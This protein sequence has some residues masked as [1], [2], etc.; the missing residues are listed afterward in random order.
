MSI[1]G[2]VDRARGSVRRLW[3]VELYRTGYLLLIGQFLA[4]LSGGVFWLLAA[5][6]YAPAVVGTG[7]AA[8]AAMQLLSGVA[9]LNMSSALVRFVPVA[10]PR[11]RAMIGSALAV[12]AALS[13]LAAVIFIAGLPWWAPGLAGMLGSP[14]M[15]IWFVASTIAW[16]VLA[17]IAPALVSVSRPAAV[18]TINGVFGVGRISFVIAL[19]ALFPTVG[20]W[21]SWTAA[22]VIAAVLTLGYLFLRVVPQFTKSSTVTQFVPTRRDIARYVGPD[23]AG[24]TCWFVTVM[25]TPLLVFNAVGPQQAAVFSLAWTVTVTLYEIATSFGQSQLAAGAAT[26]DRMEVHFRQALWQTLGLLTVPA[27][28]I[29]LAAPHILAIFGQYYAERGS[30]VLR[31]LALSAF[32][33]AVLTL[34]VVRARVLRKLGTVAVGLASMCGL[35]VLLIVVLVPRMGIDGAG[36]AWLIALTIGALGAVIWHGLHGSAGQVIR[37]LR[38]T[39]RVQ[40][41]DVVEWV[42]GTAGRRVVVDTRVHVVTETVVLLVHADGTPAVLKLSGTARGVADIDHEAAVLRRLHEA[43]ELGAWRTLLPSVLAAGSDGRRSYMLTRRMAGEAV[44]AG[45]PHLTRV[46]LAAI[47]PLHGLQATPTVIDQSLLLEWVIAPSER[48]QQVLPDRRR[49][50]EIERLRSEL[51]EV[52]AGRTVTVGWV[53]GD[54]SPGN[55]L[56]SPGQH[57]IAGIV[58]WAQASD[59]GLAVVDCANMILTSKPDVVRHLGHVVADRLASTCWT[60]GEWQLLEELSGGLPGR[61]VLRLTWL[62]HVANNLEKS[63][64]YES[65]ALW[66]HKTIYPVLGVVVP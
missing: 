21:F 43:R 46:A 56:V 3:S 33:N 64:R 59:R 50:D 8:I 47:E 14:A 20:V 15:R 24:S 40:S 60:Q 22:T 17:L 13:A 9:Q 54:Y 27:L 12:T 62:R 49:R 23:Y 41:G 63:R 45:C 6:L 28:V 37:T 36:V 26:P 29:M 35:V 11:A 53:H 18:P 30:S 58:D 57:E 66:I 42:S 31:L 4:G 25:V 39:R 5:R 2:H 48:I 55:V 1:T 52:L 7:S 19:A 16:T 32:P 61:A 38:A 51:C 10:A 44:R 34:E 65:S